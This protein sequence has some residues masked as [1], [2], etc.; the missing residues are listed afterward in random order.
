MPKIETRT[1]KAT[2]KAAPKNEA[3]VV[4]P[5]FVF[6][7]M[8]DDLLDAFNAIEAV[9]NDDIRTRLADVIGMMT[10]ARQFATK[11]VEA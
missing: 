4:I 11:N 6:D 10:T 1:A 5:A 7:A 9:V 2:R 8:K 3:T